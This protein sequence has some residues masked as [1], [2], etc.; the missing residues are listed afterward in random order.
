M[1]SDLGWYVAELM[2]YREAKEKS[3]EH[4]KK[5]EVK[6]KEY[7]AIVL[8]MLDATGQPHAEYSGVARVT[9][10]E[11]ETVFI[12]DYAKLTR[13]VKSVMT[14]PNSTEEDIFN[15]MSLVQARAQQSNISALLKAGVPEELLGVSVKKER[16]L[17][18]SKR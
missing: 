17:S 12:S 16:T 11:K 10:R 4:S 15:A 3:D 6:I 5:C 7:S 13:Y 2:K 14:D 9:A 18:V 1:S 8:A